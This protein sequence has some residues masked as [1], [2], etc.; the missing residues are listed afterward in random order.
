MFRVEDEP[1][2]LAGWRYD[3]PEIARRFPQKYVVDDERRAWLQGIGTDGPSSNFTMR[4]GAGDAIVPLAWRK[5]QQRTAEGRE[6]LLTEVFAFGASISVTRRTGTPT[7]E[8]RDAEEQ[9]RLA[10][11]AAEAILINFTIRG[12]RNLV[13]GHNR[14]RVPLHNGAGEFTLSSFGYDFTAP[15]NGA[16]HA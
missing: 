4:L 12:S 16:E 7:Y 14:V 15:E 10:I 2:E 1:V 8:F 3:N 9:D 6:Y 13:E 11:L 5:T